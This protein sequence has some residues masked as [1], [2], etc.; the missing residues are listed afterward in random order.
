MLTHMRLLEKFNHC[1]V[2]DLHQGGIRNI[3]FGTWGF[4]FV[5]FFVCLFYS[6]SGKKKKFLKMGFVL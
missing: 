1:N 3:S 5:V 2:T 4:L 6:S